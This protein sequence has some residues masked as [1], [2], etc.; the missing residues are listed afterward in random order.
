MS[1]PTLHWRHFTADA[2]LT[3]GPAAIVGDTSLAILAVPQIPWVLHAR[4]AGAGAARH[5]A[6]LERAEGA[7]Q[8]V[9]AA[10]AAVLHAPG[11]VGDGSSGGASIAAEAAIAS[12]AKAARIM[13]MAILPIPPTLVTNT[14]QARFFPSLNREIVFA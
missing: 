6:L 12:R 3:P 13:I 8:A 5:H 9:V 2:L 14:R 10:A 11:P 1:P 7:G 4:A